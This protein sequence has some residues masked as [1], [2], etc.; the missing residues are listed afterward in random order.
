MRFTPVPSPLR[1]GPVP[2]RREGRILPALQL[3]PEFISGLWS[4]VDTFGVLK[5]D[6]AR[7]GGL[8][9]SSGR[10]PLPSWFRFQLRAGN[11]FTASAKAVGSLL[12]H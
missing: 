9:Q 11:L 6:P 7:S 3:R 8:R 2:A 4:P 10:E 12:S 1:P 5:P